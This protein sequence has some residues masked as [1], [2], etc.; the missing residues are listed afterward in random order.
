LRKPYKEF[1]FLLLSAILAVFSLRAQDTTW[2]VGTELQYWADLTAYT[3]PESKTGAA[4]MGWLLNNSTLHYRQKHS[5]NLSL[6]LTHG[7]TPSL[8]EVGDLQ[9]FSNIEAG[10]LYGFYETYYKYKDERIT[11][12]VGQQDLNTDFLVSTNALLFAHSSPGIDPVS[13]LNMPAPTYPYTALAFT[14]RLKI[15]PKLDLRAGVFDGRFTPARRNFIPIAWKINRDE[16]LLYILE[17]EW[18]LLK[19][20]VMLKPSV[21]YHSGNFISPKDSSSTKGLWGF[22]LVTDVALH[23]KIGVYTQYSISKPELSDLQ[24]YAGAGLRWKDPFRHTK[25]HELGFCIAHARI[26]TQWPLTAH[27]YPIT[28]ETAFECTARMEVLSW[29]SLQPYFQM[30]LRDD[31]GAEKPEPFI[32]AL[33]IMTSF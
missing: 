1:Y 23:E 8:S 13:T 22:S 17:P 18:N 16:G 12:K 11:L 21:Y 29:L 31:I 7:G 2:Q 30:I 25:H 19:N 6:M 28:S 14:T 10:F 32:A 20:R 15:G 27:K 33:R 3:T 26:F 5:L 9:T 4:Y 24:Y